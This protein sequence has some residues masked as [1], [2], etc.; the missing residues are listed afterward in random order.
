MRTRPSKPP[1]RITD[2]NSRR[3]GK[4]Q[5]PRAKKLRASGVLIQMKTKS[6]ALLLAALVA[7]GCARQNT[8]GSAVPET[9]DA[10]KAG[11]SALGYVARVQSRSVSP[12]TAPEQG[13]PAAE[14]F[15]R[16]PG[17]LKLIW[18]AS[19][20]IEVPNFRAAV[21]QAGKAVIA[22]GGYVSDRQSSDDG[23]GHQRGQI[24]VRV[25]SERFD[26]AV[27]ALKALG[28]VRNEAV[29]TQDVTKA[30]SDLETR[31]K[32]K[33]ET[34]SR[35][36]EI[37]TRQTGKVSEV[38]EVEREIARVIEEIEQAEGE[39]R[40]FDN[41]ISLSTI[42]VSLHEP[43]AMVTPGALD[44]IVYALRQS[45][46]TMGESFGSLIELASALLP[47]IIALYLAFRVVRWRLRRRV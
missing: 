31:L 42:T 39:R 14:N 12:Q 9:K 47:W 23:A 43:A 18:T 15:V 37:L 11:F 44:P 5:G 3:G 41:Q 21:D 26:G 27:S 16:S 35:L 38:L 10:S 8:G 45:L 34:A 6:I 33:R 19:L 36:R 1:T 25:P 32:V 4:V 30:Y 2:S 20:Q 24:T 7:T 28:Q 13:S 46:R 22:L 40:Y 17:S 29:Q